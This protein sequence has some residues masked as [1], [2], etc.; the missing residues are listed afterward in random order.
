[1]VALFKFLLFYII[2]MK[3]MSM[4]IEARSNAAGLPNTASDVR[5]RLA[6]LQLRFYSA[7]FTAIVV[8][9]Y[10]ILGEYRRKLVFMVMYSFW[11]P[12][13]VYNIIT[14]SKKPLHKHYIYG[15][16]IT[17]LNLPLILFG[18]PNNF[19]QEIEPE[20]PTD[21][22]LCAM[23]IIWVGIQTSLLMAQTKYGAR[24]MIPA[25]YVDFS[26]IY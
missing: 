2:E 26:W 11:V 25:R 4:I 18:I 24:F 13:I 5:R 12:Q 16:S 17:R 3:Y 8:V 9:W 6:A 20:F 19:M 22:K 1:M 10:L 7:L 15:N 14:E 23:L 21:F